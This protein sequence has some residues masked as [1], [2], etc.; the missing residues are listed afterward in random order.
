M[1]IPLTPK[2]TSRLLRQRDVLAGNSCGLVLESTQQMHEKH[3]IPADFSK[4]KF[5]RLFKATLEKFGHAPNIVKIHVFDEKHKRYNRQTG[6]RERHKHTIF[7]MRMPFAHFRI[8]KDLAACG[9]YGHFSLNVI[10]YVAHL[11]YMMVPSAKKL[12]SDID[13]APWSYPPVPPKDLLALCATPS[14]QMEA[15]S[16]GIVVGRKRG[17]AKL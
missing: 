7:K 16:G 12:L 8:Q 6:M 2:L 3:F 14:P 17:R 11:R 1:V 9:I 5:G 10:G 4:E 15:R 13:R